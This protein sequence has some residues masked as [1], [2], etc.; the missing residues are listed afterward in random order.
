[1]IRICGRIVISLQVKGVQP[2]GVLRM[3]YLGESLLIVPKVE[4]RAYHPV[5]SQQDEKPK[6]DA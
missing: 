4:F 6:Q 5:H 2:F 1:M 3:C